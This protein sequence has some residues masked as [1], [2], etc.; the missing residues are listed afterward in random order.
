[1]K[2]LLM[3]FINLSD[4]VIWNINPSNY[5]CIISWICKNDAINLMQNAYSTEES[6]A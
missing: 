5:H 2:C 6:G 4:I 3:M 1:M